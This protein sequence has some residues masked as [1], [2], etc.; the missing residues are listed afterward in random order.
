MSTFIIKSSGKYRFISSNIESE[1][2]DFVIEPL[3]KQG[4]ITKFQNDSP[5]LYIK[6][7]IRDKIINRTLKD[8]SSYD[9]SALENLIENN[10]LITDNVEVE[11]KLTI[12]R[13]PEIITQK[14]NYYKYKFYR[15]LIDKRIYDE[16]GEPDFSDTI[17]MNENDCLK[18]GECMTVVNQK[19]DKILFDKIIQAPETAP[20]LQF[21]KDDDKERKFGEKDILNVKYLKDIIEK[22]NNAA[23][24]SGE[25]Y[26][27]VRKKF[28]KDV[29][30]F[31]IAFVL[32]R[33]GNINI[34]LEA[35]ADQGHEYYPRFGFY[36]I[37]PDGKTFHK[38]YSTFYTNAE[39]IVLKSR[40]V[41]TVLNEIKK[42]EE[43]KIAQEARKATKNKTKNKTN[44][45]KNEST[46][47]E[48]LKIPN[49]SSTRKNVRNSTR[50]S[51]EKSTK[52]PKIPVKSMK[53]SIKVPIT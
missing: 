3:F 32:C 5:G 28:V 19:N 16:K 22:D 45:R 9:Y 2:A 46:P 42:E 25:S 27:I 48:I 6:T 23:P 39:T 44:K 18:F 4:F 47:Q 29:A 36:D 34:T 14:H 17:S 50:T 8:N 20:F 12:A 15:P 38:S 11:L 43:D 24:T 13:E 33:H 30:D 10:F 40:N 49:T 26:A 35:S 41:D 7:N 1:N 51:V 37:N 52:K 21:K 53:K 31:H